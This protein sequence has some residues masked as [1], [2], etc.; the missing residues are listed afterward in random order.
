MILLGKGEEGEAISG[1][2][3]VYHNA[4]YLS[5]YVYS[6]SAAKAELPYRGGI[7]R[8]DPLWRWLVFYC[9]VRLE[10]HIRSLVVATKLPTGEDR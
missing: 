6:S 2:A 9:Y 4:A 1:V 10:C 7:A 8:I 3:K 5:S